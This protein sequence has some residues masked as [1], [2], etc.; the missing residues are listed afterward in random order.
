MLLATD[1]TVQSGVYDKAAESFGIRLVHPDQETQKI[2]M[3]VIYDQIKKGQKGNPE[4]FEKIGEAVAKAGCD[5]AILA[6]TELSV[7]REYHALPEMY[8]DAMA[9]LADK[10][11]EMCR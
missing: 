8:V 10:C 1:G 3:E 7:Y 6:C 2:V 11:V 9:V 5:S 4:S